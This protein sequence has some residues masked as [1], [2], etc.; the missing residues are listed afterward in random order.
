M[1]HEALVL[2]PTTLQLQA[3]L[4]VDDYGLKEWITFKVR[5]QDHQST[6]ADGT[7][8]AASLSSLNWLLSFVIH[9]QY[10]FC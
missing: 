3:G 8:M 6:P 10:R 7:G 9:Y 2:T 4:V 1:M 5:S